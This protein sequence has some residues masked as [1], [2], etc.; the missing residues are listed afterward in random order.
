MADLAKRRMR[1]KIPVLTEALNGQLHRASRVHDPA[2]PG[3]DRRRTPRTSPTLSERID[4]LMKPFLPARELLES[5]P[6][7][8]QIAR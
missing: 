7:F 2:V 1:S 5:I 8:C 6:G 3:P 4:E